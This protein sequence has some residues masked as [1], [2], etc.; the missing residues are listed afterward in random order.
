MTQNTVGLRLDEDTQQRLKALGKTRERSPHY[1]MKEAVERYLTTEES[2]ESERQLMKD[3]WERY[4]LTGQ[5][6]AHDDVVDW[7]KGLTNSGKAT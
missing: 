7:A 3:R 1:L 5:T 4:E 6:I 2:I